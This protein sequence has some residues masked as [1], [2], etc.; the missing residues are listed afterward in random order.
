[1]VVN[2]IEQFY[3][4][5]V[6]ADM[7]LTQKVLTNKVLDFG[8]ICVNVPG[9]IKIWDSMWSGMISDQTNAYSKVVLQLN[10]RK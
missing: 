3:D 6:I 8:V 5:C 4:I 1:M 2:V 7:E 10:Q 9:F